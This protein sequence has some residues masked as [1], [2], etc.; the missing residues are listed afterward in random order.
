MRHVDKSELMALVQAGLPGHYRP[1]QVLWDLTYACQ[2]RCTHC[3]QMNLDWN[4]KRQLPT[5][6]ILETLDEMRDL[7]TQELLFSGGD[8]FIVRDFLTMVERACANGFEVIIYSSGQ[9]IS[10]QVA[11]R[12]A[13]CEVSWVELTLMGPD[14]ETHDKVTQRRG[15]FDR[16]LEAAQALRSAGVATVGKTVVTKQNLQQLPMLA[17]LCQELDIKFK[18]DPHIWRPWNGTEAQIS[19]LKLDHAGMQEY[20]R[21][22]RQPKPQDRSCAMGVTMC[23]A[24]RS[25]AGITP[26]GK[27]NPCTTYGEGMVIG[28]LHEQTFT[29]IWLNSPMIKRYREMTSKSYPTCHACEMSAFCDWCPGLSSWAGNDY[30]E[31]YAELCNDTEIKKKLWEENTGRDWVPAPV[32]KGEPVFIPT[33]SRRASGES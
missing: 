28:D 3:Y 29:E 33:I 22:Y 19:H 25:R 1:W 21:T 9:G 13:A 15:S 10:D 6:R 23:N 18:S 17:K 11:Q 24:G 16:L 12:L 20:Y 7:G 30:T 5:R 26:F 32:V 27:V 14:A 4:V 2:L 8:P 31:P